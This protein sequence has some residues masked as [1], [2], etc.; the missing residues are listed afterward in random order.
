ML[1][2]S[3]VG[4]ALGLIVFGTYMMLKSWGFDVDII[5]WIPLVSICFTNF[6]SLLGVQ[7]LTFIVI[8]EIMPTR[9]KETGV[10]VSS[11]IQAVLSF[12]NLKYFPFISGLIGIHG[13][14]FIYA[15]V[16]L[17]GALFTILYVPETNGK[18]YTQIMKSLQ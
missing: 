13:C 5:N 15:S 11:T 4:T 17:F 12:L 3:N 18:S 16:S 2:V 10:S 7:N 9:I 6:T 1:V 8:S 14:M